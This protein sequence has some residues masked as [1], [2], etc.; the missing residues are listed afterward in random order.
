M[1]DSLTVPPKSQALKAK[2]SATDNH[3]LGQEV[4]IILATPGYRR[5]V[6]R[7]TFSIPII[8]FQIFLLTATLSL[9]PSEVGHFR[10]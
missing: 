7:Y 4:L 9:I 5:L 8:S 1:K 10:A 6:T 3:P 2:T